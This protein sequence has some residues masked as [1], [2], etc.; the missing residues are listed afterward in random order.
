MDIRSL[1][2]NI[3][4][5][6]GPRQLPP[7][8]VSSKPV[9]LHQTWG[10]Y[11]E[12]EKPAGTTSLM[13]QVG[14]VT[15]LFLIGTNPNVPTVAKQEMALTAPDLTPYPSPLK[16]RMA[17]GGGGD[18]SPIPSSQGK[19]SE[20]AA[21]QF[22]P[23]TVARN[24]ERKL[25]MEPTL[26]IQPDATI[27]RSGLDQLGDPLARSGLSSN[28]PGSGGGIGTGRGGDVGPGSGGNVS[29]GVYEIG[30]GVSAP[31][32][33]F[34]VEPE[35]SEEACKG[36]FQGTVILLLVVDELGNPRDLSVIRPLGL[37]LDQKALEAVKLWKFNPGKKD[38][39]PVSV[40]TTI[41][42]NF[43]LL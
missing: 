12:Q 2:A 4:G 33:L 41:E 29:G 10:L 6:I 37:G 31:T 7:L 22:V 26:I 28:G 17:G 24:E 11:R 1:I 15:L 21:K 9:P 16:S 32:V 34:K 35:Y 14:A 25:V 23:P 42:I 20:L 43:R 27:P 13:I 19:L 3:K 40:Q 38:G 5:W 39:K 36:K 30:A 8:Q 18:R